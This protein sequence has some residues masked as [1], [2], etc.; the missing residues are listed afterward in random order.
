[1]VTYTRGILGDRE[2]TGSAPPL[3]LG[4]FDGVGEALVQHTEQPRRRLT[5]GAPLQQRGDGREA[6]F[7]SLVRSFAV[8]PG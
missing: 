8:P 3:A 4:S 6:R 2:P 1:M 7:C 5:C